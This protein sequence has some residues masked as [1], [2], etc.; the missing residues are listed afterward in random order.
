M[1]WQIPNGQQTHVGNQGTVECTE[2]RIRQTGQSTAEGG[3]STRLTWPGPTGVFNR[4]PRACLTAVVVFHVLP[5]IL[6][7][8]PLQVGDDVDLGEVLGPD[9]EFAKGPTGVKSTKKQ[10]GLDGAAPGWVGR[11][12]KISLLTGK[13]RDARAALAQVQQQQQF[14]AGGGGVVNAPAV[15]AL[16]SQLET[17]LLDTALPQPPHWGDP[18][19]DRS[20]A[21]L[22]SS[23]SAASRPSSTAAAGPRPSSASRSGSRPPSSA[24]PKAYPQSAA[25]ASS[26]SASSSSS[27]PPRVALLATVAALQTALQP[28]LSASASA[29]GMGM[30]MG[31]VPMT[32]MSQFSGAPSTTSDRLHDRHRAGIAQIEKDRQAEFERMQADNEASVREVTA[33]RLKIEAIQAR[34]KTVRCQGKQQTEHE[35]V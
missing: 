1:A 35:C 19:F 18:A 25:S 15:Q 17:Q 34:N 23:S 33:A 9:S 7:S 3:T 20:P 6:H 12:Q 31:T 4:L 2:A 5:V 21:V 29:T 22:A 27:V 26:S 11:A 10:P 24:T 8:L 13:L 30:G 28:S 32:A 14:T 16:L